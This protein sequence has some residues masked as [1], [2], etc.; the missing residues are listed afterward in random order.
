LTDAELKE[1]Q[2]DFE[3]IALQ[4]PSDLQING[5]I[6]SGDKATVT[7]KLPGEDETKLEMQEI[8]LRKEKDGVWI[9][10]TVDETAEKMIKK[11]GKNYFYQLRIETHQDEAREML[12]RIAKAQMAYSLVN[13]NTYGDIPALIAAGFLPDDVQTSE[14][15]GYK[16]SVTLS[17]DKRLYSA[18]AVPSEYGKTGKL[19]F[20][21]QIMPKGGAKLTSKDNGG[22]V[23]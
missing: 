15:T 8:K 2:V 13:S 6:I 22:K 21:V 12:D 7:A 9:I 23:F 17:S 5:E 16:Y 3:K 19:S 14:S 18:S 4:I 20:S 10:L 1:F 11:E